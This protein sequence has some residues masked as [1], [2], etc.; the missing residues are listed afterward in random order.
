MALM[1]FDESTN[2]QPNTPGLRDAEG[3]AEGVDG[4]TVI[5][6]MASQQ[7]LHEL[8]FVLSLRGQTSEGLDGIFWGSQIGFFYEEIS[9]I[10]VVFFGFVVFMFTFGTKATPGV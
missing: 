7:R 8:H 9:F 6:T 10:Q 2:Q 1:M 3:V 5:V 4:G